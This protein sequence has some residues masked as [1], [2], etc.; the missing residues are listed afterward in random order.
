MEESRISLSQR[1][2]Y[3]FDNTMSAGTVALI[4]W[5]AIISLAA[6]AIVAGIAT[7]LGITEETEEANFLQLFWKSLMRT[8]DAG[9]LS[10]DEAWGPRL[11]MLL[12]TIV[13]IF[14]VSILI[15][16]VTS[17]IETKLDE[18]RKGR[19]FV[20]ETDHT[21][22]L[23]WSSKIFSII[24]ELIVAN[25]N[26]RNAVIVIL[27]DRDKVEMEEEL[28]LKIP[29]T[30]NTRVICRSGTAID[31]DHLHIA[32]PN[33]ARSII[34]LSPEDENADAQV[35]KSILALVNN[36]RRKKEKYHIVAEIQHPEN[37]PVAQMVGKDELCVLMSD[38]LISRITVQTCRH[39]GLSVVYSELLDFEGVEIYFQQE[40]A[41]A[42]KT[43]RE[44]VLGYEDSAIMGL[45]RKNG[46]VVLNP[47]PDTKVES[48][49]S[50]I[51]IS[52]DDDTVRLSGGPP[53]EIRR[54]AITSGTPPSPRKERTLLLGWNH[55]APSIIMNLDD[56]VTPGSEAVVVARSEAVGE[57]VERLKTHLN[58]QTVTFR[59]A[60]TT[61][62]EI[63]E[64]LGIF[65]FQNVVLL[66]Y[67]DIPPQEADSLTLI[68]LLHLRDMIDRSGRPVNIVSEMLDLRNRELA[69]VTRV[70]D[71]IV[72]DK[73][74][75]LMLAQLSENRDLKAVYDDL[76]DE[77][78]NEIYIKPVSNY[79]RTGVAVDFYT[80][81]ESALQKNESVIGYRLHRYE[82]DP[83]KAY[84]IVVNP[85]KSDTV[86]FEPEDKIIVVSE[87]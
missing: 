8:L 75:S 50:V 83:G 31:M 58:R 3:R 61:D 67:D 5:L 54:D 2:R 74:T 63:L 80:V 10:G 56:Y 6:T 34:I 49:D 21:L 59:R 68:T 65:D 41:L 1:W 7:V 77:E 86:T 20:V 24:G 55:K 4:K 43:Y 64:E 18:L 25:S 53:P 47:A 17:A 48:G 40:P 45:Q 37:L 27:A 78:G 14:L 72:S 39:S 22:I 73:L 44:A 26:R 57:A 9:N 42:G 23:S 30:R 11:L 70:N 36:P 85:R 52:E 29:D 71:F 87:N 69:T 51:A 60:D 19:S 76:F 79:V 62:R 13:G 15:G 46:A 28:R 32:N 82:E 81:A 84:G 33:A 66:C 16:I 12:M 35:I 38:D